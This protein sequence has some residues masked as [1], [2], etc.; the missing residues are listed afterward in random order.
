MAKEIER[1]FLVK[2]KSYRDAA[3]RVRTM[4]QAYLSL[5]PEATVRVRIL[6]GEARLTVK[7]INRGAERSEWE[8]P[9]PVKDAEE[10]LR[11]CSQSTLI[12][13]KRYLVPAREEGLTWE[14]DEFEGPLSGLVLAEVELPSADTPVSLPPFIG[15]E[16]TGDVRYYNSSLASGS[17]EVPPCS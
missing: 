5:R 16:V 15:R 1:K 14:I 13:K 3:T 12:I 17:G 7:S 4:M 8:Y 2:D 9:I 6:D 10:M 11:E